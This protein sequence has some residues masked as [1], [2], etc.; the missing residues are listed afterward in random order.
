MSII[1][2]DVIGSTN[3][4][5]ERLLAA[6]EV[7]IGDTIVADKQDDGHGRLGRDFVSP[8]GGLYMTVLCPADMDVPTVRAAV[9]T[10]KVL[11]EKFGVDTKIKWI[12]DITLEGKKVCGILANGI[13]KAQ[14]GTDAADPTANDIGAVAIGIGVN[15]AAQDCFEE[16]EATFIDTGLEAGSDA[17]FAKRDEIAEAIATD[18]LANADKAAVI[19]AY[20]EDSA[21]LGQRI[22]VYKHGLDKP[23]MDAK[24]L[25]IDD[26][27]G[28]MVQYMVKARHGTSG[29]GGGKDTLR[30]ANVTIRIQENF[31]G[32]K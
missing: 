29:F 8:V 9:S 7:Q 20:K 22:F 26:N 15:F 31:Q 1:K 5:A 32:R 16:L 24:V 30:S 13:T 6:G 12:N 14:L 27:G 11:K 23:A 4:E 28:L 25:G 21:V 3:D 18:L 17:F 10:N 2:Y 19:E